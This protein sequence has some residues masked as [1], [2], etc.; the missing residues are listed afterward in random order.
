[1]N[2]EI[3]KCPHLKSDAITTAV[4]KTDDGFEIDGCC[5]GQ[6]STITGIVF[7][8][9]CGERLFV[10][11]SKIDMPVRPARGTL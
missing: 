8:P 9:F 2:E 3:A 4:H 6:C 5:G 11:E 7:C 10:K 1:V